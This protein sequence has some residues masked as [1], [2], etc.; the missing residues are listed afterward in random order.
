MKFFTLKDWEHTPS[1]NHKINAFA[2]QQ[3]RAKAISFIL[4][5]SYQLKLKYTTICTACIYFHQ[6]YFRRSFGMH[7][8]YD[9]ACACIHFAC[10]CEEDRRRLS[11][12]MET[13]YYFK[14][15]TKCPKPQ[16]IEYDKI[17]HTIQEKE[18]LLLQTLEF[19]FCV[20]Q[21][22]DYL[23]LILSYWKSLF[24]PS[25]KEE[26]TSAI[27]S[28]NVSLDILKFY[29]KIG[30]YFI[31]DCLKLYEMVV[32][33]PEHIAIA[34]MELSLRY[35]SIAY[36]EQKINDLNT[37]CITNN[38]NTNGNHMD[39][40]ADF[41][42]LNERY[43]GSI[44]PLDV[45]LM[46]DDECILDVENE[47]YLE[48]EPNMTLDELQYLCERIAQFSDFERVLKVKQK[49]QK[50]N[51]FRINMQLLKEWRKPNNM[52]VQK[53]KQGSKEKPIYEYSYKA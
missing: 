5:T 47:W 20:V 42:Q 21:P 31:F 19:D 3:H 32:Y 23:V 33:C 8:K 27:E 24:C 2:E 38:V 11:D 45:F 15:S 43:Y 36:Q 16:S 37:D 7:D 12:V 26:K 14:F 44:L 28:K 6:F 17:L 25:L 40:D 49:V 18:L 35:V 50:E 52:V 53:K 30:W 39:T 4:R 13:C 22:F 46:N 48:L 10:K 1:R 9:I 34:C 29:F 41:N 51:G